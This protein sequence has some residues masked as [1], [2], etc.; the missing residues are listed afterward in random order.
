MCSHGEMEV[1]PFLARVLQKSHVLLMQDITSGG[2]FMG[3][4]C[5]IAGHVNLGHGHVVKL[6][7]AS[8]FHGKAIVFPLV[9]SSYLE[10]DPLRQCN[11]STP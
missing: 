6:L 10:G 7:S 1:V 5:L 2:S 8:G 9:I 11:Y 4:M 3:L